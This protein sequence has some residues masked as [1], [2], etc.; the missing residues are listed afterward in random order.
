GDD[1]DF[2]EANHAHVLSAAGEVERLELR[3]RQPDGP[4]TPLYREPV[5]PEIDSVL[6][7]FRALTP[8]SEYRGAVLEWLSRHYR[9]EENLARA[10]SGAIAELLAPF[11]V[12]VFEASHPA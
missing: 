9:P 12:V 11:G 3:I 8:E 5:G 6:E 7:R 4:L 10:F 1:H 2:A